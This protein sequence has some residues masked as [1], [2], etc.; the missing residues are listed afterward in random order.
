MAS[1]SVLGVSVLDLLALMFGV[2]VALLIFK[3]LVK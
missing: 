2:G 1:I 3:V